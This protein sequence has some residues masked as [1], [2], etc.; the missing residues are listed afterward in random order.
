MI[1][2]LHGKVKFIESDHIIVDVNGIGYEVLTILPYEYKIDSEVSL[3]VYTHV[4]EDQFLLFGFKELAIKKLFLK[5]IQV[6]GVGPKT[7]IGI[8]SSIEYQTFIEAIDNEDI[9]MLKKIPGIGP[10]S[11]GQIVLDL[12]GKLVLSNNNTNQDLK[13]AL[14]A[15]S[16]LGYK[17]NEIIKVEKALASEML[18]IE[19]YIKQGL[20]ILL[21]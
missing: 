6:K 18:S 14:D 8:L 4:R 1:G 5:L 9:G 7:A 16:A 19:E 20:K 11:A 10:K 3:Y 13:D 21:K 2:Y 12:K 15:L 17:N